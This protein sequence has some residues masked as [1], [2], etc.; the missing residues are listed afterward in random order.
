MRRVTPECRHFDPTRATQSR[1]GWA[2]SAT[3]LQQTVVTTP[4][5]TIIFPAIRLVNY[6]AG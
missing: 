1:N 2:R 4:G 5:P 6:L 3:K